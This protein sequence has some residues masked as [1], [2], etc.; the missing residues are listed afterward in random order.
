MDFDWKKGVLGIIIL[1]VLIVALFLTFGPV[2]CE[3]VDCF[4]QRMIDCSFATYINEETEAS[5]G[6][7]ILGN[8]GNQCE[9]EVT[10]LSA[11]EGNLGLRNYE[12]NSMSC[13]YDKGIF[14]YPEKNLDVCIGELKEN[15]QSVIIEKLY[16]YVVDNLGE[17]EEE[18]RRV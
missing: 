9:I 1:I 15:L 18:L 13:F 3:G 11:K 7:E 8:K 14:A 4:Q 17:I 2:K 6:Y 12:G 16:K 5:W 10:L